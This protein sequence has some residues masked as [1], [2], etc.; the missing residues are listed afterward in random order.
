MAT[1]TTTTT[2][3]YGLSDATRRAVREAGP[4]PGKG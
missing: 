3:S 1:T 4:R 2:P